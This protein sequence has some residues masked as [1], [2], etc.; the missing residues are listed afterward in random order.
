VNPHDPAA[1]PALTS[2]Q[3]VARKAAEA[4]CRDLQAQLK[5]SGEA[6]A[7]QVAELREMYNAARASYSA[8]LLRV[9]EMYDWLWLAANLATQELLLCLCCALM[10]LLTV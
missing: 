3:M 9:H 6:A 5:A 7:L 8:E 1:A 4:M 2:L 10:A